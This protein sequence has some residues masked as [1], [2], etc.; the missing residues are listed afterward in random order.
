MVR[1]TLTSIAPSGGASF[2][3]LMMLL[4]QTGQNYASSTFL[5]VFNSFPG[6]RNG[7][8]YKILHTTLPKLV[9][10]QFSFSFLDDETRCGDM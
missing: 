5:S 1:R 2:H 8:T 6:G 7:S 3:L 10:P 4:P 9:D